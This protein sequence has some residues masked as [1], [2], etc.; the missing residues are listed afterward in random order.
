MLCGKEASWF[1]HLKEMT[2][3]EFQTNT[4][5]YKQESQINY[6]NELKHFLKIIHRNNK[7]ETEV[8]LFSSMVKNNLINGEAKV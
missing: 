3:Q 2:Q 6:R 1:R 8:V 7:Q 5:N 4:T